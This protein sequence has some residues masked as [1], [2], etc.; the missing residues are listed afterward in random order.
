MLEMLY[1]E[2]PPCTDNNS[3]IS[4]DD[5]YIEDLR[6]SIMLWEDMISDD[7]GRGD[8]EMAKLDRARLQQAKIDLRNA[9]MMMQKNNRLE[10]AVA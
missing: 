3:E 2:N 6:E 4:I 9:K 7:I 1:G 10:N 5:K 8:K